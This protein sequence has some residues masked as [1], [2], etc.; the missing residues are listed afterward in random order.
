VHTADSPLGSHVEALDVDVGAMDLVAHASGAL[1]E[2]ALSSFDVA[3]SKLDATVGG[4]AVTVSPGAHASWQPGHLA[5]QGLAVSTGASRLTVDGEIDGTPAHQ[6][7]MSVDGRLD[8]FRP[9]V[10][11]AL[12]EGYDTLVMAGPISGVVRASGALD[13]PSIDGSLQV[14]DAEIGDGVHP[15]A[16][17]VTLVATIDREKLSIEVAEA[18]WQGAHLAV[19]GT[20]PSRFLHIR[21]GAARRRGQPEGPPRQR[22][23]QGAGAVRRHRGAAGH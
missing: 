20:V 8:D 15:S 5:V 4:L 12:P 9:L 22:D 3:V 13:L 14:T 23:D 21:G 16:T 2:P 17:G 11:Q 7:T 1:T 19:D 10:A 18:H 6:L